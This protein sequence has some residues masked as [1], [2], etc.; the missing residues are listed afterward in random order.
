MLTS[1]RRLRFLLLCAALLVFWTA[2]NDDATHTPVATCGDGVVDENEEC[3]DAGESETCNADCTLAA[4]GDGI[5]NTQAGEF[6]DDGKNN[7]KPNHCDVDCRYITKPVCGNGIIEEGDELDSPEFCDDGE[8]NGKPNHCN[9]W[10]TAMTPPVCG[11]GV[12]EDGEACDDGGESETCNADCTVALCGDG[13]VNERA[14]EICDDGEYNGKGGHCNSDCTAIEHC[15]NAVVDDGEVCDDGEN[16]GKPG[17]CNTHCSGVGDAICGNGIIENGEECDDE[18][19]S[20][21]CNANCTESTCGDGF[22]NYAAGEECDDGGDSFS[23]TADCKAKDVAFRFDTVGFID[24]HLFMSMLGCNDITNSVP[25]GLLEGGANGMLQQGLENTKNGKFNNSLALIL[26]PLIQKHAHENDF[27]FV[28]PNCDSPLGECS[29]D[30]S[31]PV[32]MSRAQNQ[33]SDYCLPINE[34]RGRNPEYT[35]LHKPSGPCFVS[36]YMDINIT[37]R[38]ITLSLTDTRVTAAYTGRPATRLSDGILV[39]FLS[40]EAAEAAIVPLPAALG[41]KPLIDFLKGG[42]ACGRGDDSDEHNGEEGWWFYLNFTAQA[43]EAWNE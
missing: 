22:V 3:D 26:R 10:C 7:G 40:R 38:N 30:H 31:K 42:G 33:E 28:F 9:K 25:L 17:Y 34:Q 39:G 6:C 21:T 16:N 37:I 41:D 23:C 24:P 8:N 5:L 12:V 18:G 29:Q 13:Q 35:G 20:E 15:G 14:G 4:C 27:D 32:I 11:N 19:E 43:A 2:C 36:D 1:A